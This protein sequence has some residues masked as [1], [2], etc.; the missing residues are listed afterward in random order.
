MISNNKISNLVA[1]Q[2]PFFVRND[3]ENFVAFVEAYY[4]FLEQQNGVVNVS[5]NLLNQADVDLT[6]IFVENFYNNFLPFIPKDTAVDKTLILKNIKDFYRSKGTEKSIRFLMR[7][8]FNEDVE[9]YYPQRDVLKVSD[10]KWFQ[11]KSI[12]IDNVKV[13]GVANTQLGVETKFINRRITGDVSNAYALIESTSSYYEGSSLVRELKLSNQYKEFSYGE[14]ITSTFFEGTSEKTI[15]ANLFSGGINT[16]EII[17]GGSRYIKNQVIPIES[18]TGTGAEII[19]SSVSSGD[20]TAI[21]AL[22]GGAGFQVGNQVLITGGSGSG[23]NANVSAVSADG[24]YHPNSYNIIYTT[25]QSIA[26]ANINNVNYGLY[27]SGFTNPANANTT[28]ANSLSYFV[29][30]NTG[31]ITGVLLYNLGSGYTTTPS[32]SAQANTRVRSLGI[33]GKMRIVDGGE[34]YYIGDTIEFINVPGG[35]GSGAA[36]RVAN[37]DMSQGNAI[38]KVEFVNVPGQI[39]GGSGYEQLLLPIANVV[40]SN[41][42]AYGAN[43]QVTAI[44][45][46]GEILYSAGST[47]GRILSLQILKSGSGYTTPPILNFTQIGDGTAQAVTTIITGA[48]TYPGRYL[49]D[50]G[51]ISSYNF[52]QDRDY[53]QKFSYVVKVKQSMDKY[54]SVLKN[55]VH[56]AGMKLFGEYATVDEGVNLNLSIRETSDNTVSTKTRTYDFYK[57]NVGINYS[58]HGLNTDDIVYLEWLTGNLSPSNIATAVAANVIS[59]PY[60][61]VAG[62]YKIRTVVNTDYFI[63]NTV[64]YI[65]NTYTDINLVDLPT[66]LANTLL[67][68]TSGTVNVGKVIY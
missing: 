45:G 48:F 60:D 5:K 2:V 22:N 11:E 66:Y 4:E 62:P 40:S 35:T 21:A 64:P 55:L 57:G 6:D 32:I 50:D 67:P 10:G 34:G 8:L 26:S 42:Q 9:F 36:A 49:N 37:V 24:F 38:S 58:S 43:V 54:R 65:A 17:N 53:Y 59:V 25:I 61:S 3:H 7:V 23:A 1:S 68:N 31:P 16:V 18:E 30:A 41:A 12:K 28:L 14:G 47:E 51:H 20:L 33:L 63:I 19:V 56:P 39:T 15:T 27:F 13:N 46:S 44:L 29:Y 52:I